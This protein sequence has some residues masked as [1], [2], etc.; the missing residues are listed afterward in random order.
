MKKDSIIVS[1]ISVILI[2]LVVASIFFT[3]FSMTTHN[4]LVEKRNEVYG[5]QAQIENVL[6][7][8]VEKIPDL[9]KVVERYDLHE[10]KVLIEVT[11]AREG[12]DNALKSGDMK[13][14]SD[15]DDQVTSALYNL[16]VVVENYP[17]LK[18]SENYTMLIDEISGSVNRIAQERRKYNQCVQEY[19]TLV[20][21]MP[22]NII[23]LL[24]GFKPMPYFTASE[25]AHSTNVVDFEDN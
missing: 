24:Y 11:K 7:A 9:V 20:E 16:Q 23:A 22:T 6:Q 4:K 12:F 18:S 8:R 17:E 21:K 15:A 13:A 1:V 5:Q 2:T 3:I 10:E 25:E 14:I 19:N